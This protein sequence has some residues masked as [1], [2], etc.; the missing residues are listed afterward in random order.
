MP[1]GTAEIT[2]AMSLSRRVL[3]PRPSARSSSSRMA[4]SW[5][6]KRERRTAH[7]TSTVAI[8]ITNAT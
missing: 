3:T 6:P 8:R 7:D 4:S 1:I 5:R 2:K